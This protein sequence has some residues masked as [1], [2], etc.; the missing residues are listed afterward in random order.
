MDKEQKM[1]IEGCNSSAGG[2]SNSPGV[3]GSI[4]E[5][6]LTDSAM[7]KSEGGFNGLGI[8]NP[9]SYGDGRSADGESLSERGTKEKSEQD[10]S[11]DKNSG[12]TSISQ[13][14][15]F[16]SYKTSESKYA[17]FGGPDGWQKFSRAL[18]PN[19]GPP[20]GVDPVHQPLPGYNYCGP[21][22]N[23]LSPTSKLDEACKQHD[24]C[25]ESC[26]LSSDDVNIFDPGQDDGPSCQDN[27]DDNLCDAAKKNKEWISK[28]VE[29]L[30]CD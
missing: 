2:A 28:G 3:G 12:S 17:G 8:G 23:G 11:N 26:K 25:Y 15:L 22:N 4:N 29:Y 30:F 20:P 10:N 24:E 1:G 6:G 13:E 7:T 9:S 19:G 18:S 27:C 21:G 16:D 14:K 5:G